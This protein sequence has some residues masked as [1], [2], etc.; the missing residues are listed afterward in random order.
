M[1]RFHDITSSGKGFGAGI[2]RIFSSRYFVYL[3]F[4]VLMMYKMILLH[5][6]L[7]LHNVDMNPLDYLIAIGS[8]MLVSF[9]TLLLPSRGRVI[10]LLILNLLLTALI[11]SDLVYFRY[12]ED[13]ITIPVLMQAGQVG[14]LGE[15]IESLIH[16][17]DLLYFID[18]II[19]VPYAVV[20]L[21]RKYKKK[22]GLQFASTERRHYIPFLRRLAGAA[23]AFIIGYALTF[24][25]IKF[26]NE[27]WAKGLFVGNWWS[28]SI[29]NVTGLLGFHGYDAYRYA[30]DQ[31]SS[32]RTLPQE[33]IDQAK[34]WFDNKNALANEDSELF[35][36]YKNSNVIVVQIEAFMNF[37][38]NQRINDQEITPNFNKLMN[39]SMYFSNYYHQTSQGRTSDADFTSHSSL[40]PLQ[41]GSVFIRYPDHT[42]DMLPS[43]L[44]DNGYAANVY[45]AY[46]SSFWNRNIMYQAMGYDRFYSKKDFQIDEPLGWSLGDKSFYRQSL[47]YMSSTEQPFYSF[48][49]TLSSHHPYTIPKDKQELDTGEF[50]GTI[51][52]D[53]LQA[54][55]YADAA[56]GEFVAQLKAEGL[57]ENTILYVYGDH[58]N[59]IKEK[60]YYEQFTGKSLNDLDMLQIMNQVP[61]LIH[62]PDSSYAGVYEEASGMLDMTPSILHL[63]G[64]ST[65]PYYMMGND[66][67][68]EQ[69][70]LVVLR[71]GA[72]TNAKVTFIPSQSGLFEDG[73]CFDLATRELTEITACQAGYTEAKER[74]IISD[75][76]INYDLIAKFR[77]T[78]E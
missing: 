20:M 29:Y 21:R 67:F 37:V 72:F 61:M 5:Y 17:S 46:E 43:I 2:Q 62:L 7:K 75:R 78:N 71:S 47:E 57:W 11:Y 55:H 32:A 36:K 31:I 18:W 28:M 53:Y 4:F 58:D 10:S 35:G 64:I 26:Y 15:S 73:Q 6:S 24:G 69:E 16:V 60:S 19:F 8:L 54:I 77:K 70:R 14:A 44:K 1:S 68:N 59:S 49:I 66:L 25:P 30:K 22:N 34:A 52:G 40:H 42:F 13:F 48:L 38:I 3:L 45:H 50:T 56:L 76:I 51:F 23:V 9:W 74:L 41:S 63:L 65:E 12:F 33:E 39:E 27:T